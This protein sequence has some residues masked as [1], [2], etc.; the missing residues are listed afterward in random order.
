MSIDKGLSITE[1]P[2]RSEEEMNKKFKEINNKIN[3]IS[4]LT[5][6]EYLNYTKGKE[7]GN[8]TKVEEENDEN[9]FSTVGEFFEEILN[10]METILKE[11]F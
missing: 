9:S 7:K 4:N 8:N 11:L 3:F 1:G 2:A 5:I 6:I 10:K